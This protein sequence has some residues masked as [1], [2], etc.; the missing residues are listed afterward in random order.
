MEW[1]FPKGYG[2][3]FDR[4]FTGENGRRTSKSTGMGLY[5]CKKVADQ[6]NFK[7]EVASKVSKYTEFKIIF[8]KLSDYLMVTK[9][10]IKIPLVTLSDGM[11]LLYELEYR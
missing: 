9:C 5:I 4:G 10:N 11:K 2:Q 7:I 1:V 8:Y 6:L 3:G